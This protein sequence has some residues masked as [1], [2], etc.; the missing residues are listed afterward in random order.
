MPGPWPEGP[1]VGD[2]FWRLAELC[3]TTAI[4]SLWLS[5]RL[6]QLANTMP[7][8][9]HVL[10]PGTGLG[11]QLLGLRGVVGRRLDLQREVHDAGDDHAPRRAVSQARRL[12]DLLAIQRMV[13]G[14]AQAPVDPRRL[15]I[16]L[17]GEL[18]PVDGRMARGHD[19]QT[20]VTLHGLGIGAVQRI[21]MSASP[22]FSMAARVVPS[23]TL[24]MIR[25]LTFGVFRQYPGYASRTTST[26]GV[27]LTN[28]YVFLG[29]DE[30]RR[31]GT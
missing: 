7:V 24:F 10:S 26:P 16:L 21:A 23:G 5:D 2:R 9:G 4:D 29:N 1:A 30:T 6:L 12:V 17:V 8:L 14:Q 27:W 11:E 19:L 15:G 18:D 31:G 13:D 28:R 20:R 25:R 3:E 22:L